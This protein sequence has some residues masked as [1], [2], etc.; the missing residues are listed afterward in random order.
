MN[1]LSPNISSYADQHTTPESSVL[2][3]LYRETHLK[4]LVPQMLSGHFQGAVL[5]LISQLMQPTTILEIGT[6][7]GY[8]AI[9]LCAGL[10]EDGVLHTIEID[11]E[12]ATMQQ[13]YFQKAGVQNKI[14][15]HIGNALDIIPSIKGTFDLVFL[16][17]DKVNYP[18]YYDLVIDRVQSGGVILADNVLWSGKVTRPI[19]ANDADTQ[20]LDA[21]NRLVQNDPRV[22][23]ILLPIR[24]G[25]MIA[26]K[27]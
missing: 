11:E 27:K 6:Y 14:K 15:T 5:R 26:R 18:N 13:K 4:V 3:Q 2:Y 16:D 17:A 20:A 19:A 22:E 21:Y 24:D 12:L 7:T 9:C 25:I 1:F 23:N 10:A 8:S